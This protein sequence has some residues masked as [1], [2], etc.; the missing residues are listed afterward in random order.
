MAKTDLDHIT[1]PLLRY[2]RFGRSTWHNELAQKMLI[3]PMEE[4]LGLPASSAEPFSIH[5][6]GYF[7]TL[8]SA[9]KSAAPTQTTLCFDPHPGGGK[10]TFLIRFLPELNE[11][12]TL[13]GVL[14]IAQEPA[15]ESSPESTDS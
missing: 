15:C 6:A 9:L 4:M 3:E 2:D 13:V 5:V 14:A 10:Q 1:M 8:H 12:G 11:E 7:R